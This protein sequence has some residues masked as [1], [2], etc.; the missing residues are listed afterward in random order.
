MERNP[1]EAFKNNINWNIQC[2]EQL[3]PH[4]SKNEVMIPTDKAVNHQNM[5]GA[6]KQLLAE[7]IVTSLIN[8]ANQ[9]TVRFVSVMYLVVVVSGS[10]FERSD[11]W[12]PD[13]NGDRLPQIIRWPLNSH[14]VIHAV[15]PRMGDRILDMEMA[16]HMRIYDLAKKMVLLSVVILKMKSQS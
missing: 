10:V 14:L 7:L 16:N 11:C 2:Y 8:V 15:M 4:S 9:P 1:K 5:A 3:T 6:A 12:R 13:Y